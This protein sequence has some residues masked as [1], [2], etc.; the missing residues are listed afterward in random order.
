VAYRLAPLLVTYS[1]TEGHVWCLKPFY[2]TYL[3][4]YSVYCLL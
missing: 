1:D 2:L 3:G 4:N